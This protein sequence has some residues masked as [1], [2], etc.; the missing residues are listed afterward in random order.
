MRDLGV[1][2]FDFESGSSKNNDESLHLKA[3]DSLDHHENIDSASKSFDTNPDVRLDANNVDSLNKSSLHHVKEYMNGSKNH[4]KKGKIDS[5]N[6]NSSSHHDHAHDHSNS[7]HAHDHSH[8]HVSENLNVRAAAIHII[9][10]I[11]QAIGVLIAAILIYACPEWQVID[12]ICTF[13]FSILV[14]FT[15]YYIV[16]D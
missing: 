5:T 15:T 2:D 9:G 4:D 14:M 6:Y 10:D 1:D 16:K 3:Y 7:H 12:P 8:H 13:M 11:V